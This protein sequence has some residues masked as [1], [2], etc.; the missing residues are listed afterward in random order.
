MSKWLGDH[1]YRGQGAGR[2]EKQNAKHP[3]QNM[4]NGGRTEVHD[5][6]PS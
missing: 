5:M 4:A 2:H 3:H 1:G 6:T